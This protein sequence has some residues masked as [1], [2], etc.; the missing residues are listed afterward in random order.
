MCCALRIHL[1]G[2]SRRRGGNENPQVHTCNECTFMH[3]EYPGTEEI[4]I[5]LISRR[6]LSE[7]AIYVLSASQ[8]TSRKLTVSVP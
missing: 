5:R 3:T 1:L 6:S 7:V 2:F 8:G 4:N